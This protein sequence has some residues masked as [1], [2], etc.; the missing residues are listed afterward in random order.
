MLSVLEIS[1]KN[2]AK[3]I[4]PN[5][6]I[7]FKIVDDGSGIDISTLIVEVAGFRAITGVDFSEGFSGP[8]SVINPV[9][10]DYSVVIESE[11]GFDLDSMIAVRVWVKNLSNIGLAHFYSFKIASSKPFLVRSSPT[12]SLTIK[13]PQILYFHFD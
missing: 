3:N 10:D 7:E 5:S 6:L 8:S 9:G 1:P 13:T 11:S 4:S 2:G 12:D